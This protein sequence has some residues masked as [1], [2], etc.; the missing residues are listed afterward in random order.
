MKKNV[1]F[2]NGVAD[3]HKVKVRKIERNSHIQWM[4]NG[5]AHVGKYLENHLFHRSKILLDTTSD[6]EFPRQIIHGIFN[7][8]SDPDTHKIALQKAEDFYKS[9]CTH[10]PFFN[11]PSRVM[12]TTRDNIYRLLQGIDKLH[13]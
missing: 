13:V 9:V 12:Q 3:N 8:I 10:I 2:I 4:M 7:E 5:S 6:Q 1:L 11:I